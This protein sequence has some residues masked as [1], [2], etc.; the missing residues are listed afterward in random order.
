MK[1]KKIK[2]IWKVI[3]RQVKP[4]NLLVLIILLACN[5]FAWFIYSKEVQSNVDVHVRSWKVVLQDGNSQAVNYINVSIPNAYPGM[6]NFSDQITIYNQGESS[7][8]ITYTIMS[9]SIM[10][11]SEDSLEKKTENNAT[12]TGDERTSAQILSSLQSDYPFVINLSVS[13]SAVAAST[14]S[15][16]YTTS[17]TWAYNSGDDEEDTLWGTRAYNFITANPST[18]CISLVVKV[19]ITQDT[20]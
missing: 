17:M 6:A 8:H 18:S 3:K 7:A 16:V 15:A 20:N 9:I 2:I 12:L 11:V 13:N 14:G 10:G 19:V 4:R 1:T 5:S